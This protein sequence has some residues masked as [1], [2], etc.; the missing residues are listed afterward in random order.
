[1]YQLSVYKCEPLT[2]EEKNQRSSRNRYNGT[3]SFNP[4]GASREDMKTTCVLTVELSEDEFAAVKRG[5]MQ[6]M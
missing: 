4:N 1:M 3:D 5:V 2:E 6:V